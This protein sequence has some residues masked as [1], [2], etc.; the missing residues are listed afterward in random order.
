MAK[1]VVAAADEIPVG[2]RK[3]V[4]I[5]GRPIAIFNVDG[6]LFAIADSCPH[7]GGSLCHGKLT[8]LVQS[9]GPGDYRLSRHGEIIRCPWHGWEFDLRTGQSY[10]DPARIRVPQFRASI[11]PGTQVVEG[12]YVADTFPVDVDGDYVVVD[13]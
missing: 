5:N 7:E 11:E 9:S 10:C 3:L 12:P 2:S 1:Q 4:I 13:M 6:E 8:G